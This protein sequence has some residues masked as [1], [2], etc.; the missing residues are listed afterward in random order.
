MNTSLKAALL[1]VIILGAAL[2]FQTLQIAEKNRVIEDLEIKL[3]SVQVN[4]Q[5]PPG[6]NT[7]DSMIT[8][9]DGSDFIQVSRKGI[10]KVFKVNCGTCN[11]EGKHVIGYKSQLDPEVYGCSI[12]RGKGVATI[13][14]N[15]DSEQLCQ[16]CGGMGSLGKK[17]WDGLKRTDLWTARICSSCKGHGKTTSLPDE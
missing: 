11:G 12:C 7:S 6:H 17:Q 10:Q 15:P 5:A 13:K 4:D 16:T 3:N 1:L 14:L 8:I 9:G 2:G